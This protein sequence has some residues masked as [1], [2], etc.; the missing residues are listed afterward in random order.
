MYFI[1][2][3]FPEARWYYNAFTL[4]HHLA[5]VASVSVGLGAKEDR[6]TGFSVF[7][8]RENRARAKN[9]RLGWGIGREETL[10]DKPLDFENPGSPANRSRD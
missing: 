3:A 1:Y 6:G 7:C 4:E 10:A 2:H 8:L 9:E 5:R